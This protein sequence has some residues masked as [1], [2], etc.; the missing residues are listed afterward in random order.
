MNMSINV[1]IIY[2]FVAFVGAMIAVYILYAIMIPKGNSSAKDK[3]FQLT[4]KNILE[5]VRTLFDKGEYALV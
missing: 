4:T 5:H 2:I 1:N 3:E